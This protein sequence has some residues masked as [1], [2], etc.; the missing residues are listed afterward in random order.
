MLPTREGKFLDGD[1]LRRIYNDS[2][3]NADKVPTP[4]N[5]S[6]NCPKFLSLKICGPSVADVPRLRSAS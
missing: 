5:S 4:S 2:N 1:V 3:W 6:T